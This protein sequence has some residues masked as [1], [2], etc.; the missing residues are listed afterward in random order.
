MRQSKNGTAA[1]KR[2]TV[3]PAARANAQRC[4]T[5]GNP[6]MGI[7]TG[8]ASRWPA[9]APVFVFPTRHFLPPRFGQKRVLTGIPYSLQAPHRPTTLNPEPAGRRICLGL[10]KTYLIPGKASPATNDSHL[11]LMITN[12]L[13]PPARVRGMVTHRPRARRRLWRPRSGPRCPPPGSPRR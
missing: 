7:V 12:D 8:W 6:C 5:A 9:H 13:F 2:R 11:S 4:R 3:H 10:S 1:S